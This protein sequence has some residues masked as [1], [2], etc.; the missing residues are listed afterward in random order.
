MNIYTQE[1]NNSYNYWRKDTMSVKVAAY[2]YIGGLKNGSVRADLMT[3]SQTGKYATLLELQNDAAKNYLWRSSTI[4]TPR[5]GGSNS[6]KNKSKNPMTQPTS[7]R[8]QPIVYGQ[9]NSGSHGNFG[10]S[11]SKGISNTKGS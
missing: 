11:A 1:F 3:I 6:H 9:N 8:H 10:D 5:S 2:L 7:K 4:L